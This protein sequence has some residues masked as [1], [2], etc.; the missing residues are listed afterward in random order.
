MKTKNQKVPASFKRGMAETI[1]GN[2]VN[3]GVVLA[4]A[5]KKSNR[6]AKRS[7]M[8]KRFFAM[9][10]HPTP[11]P[12]LDRDGL[13]I[14]FWDNIETAMRE[15]EKMPIVK[16]VGVLIFDLQEHTV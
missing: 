2:V 8:K 5:N 4:D 12:V 10:M 1:S 15:T 9:I 16:A 7:T 13:T 3:L 14:A 6:R 11:A